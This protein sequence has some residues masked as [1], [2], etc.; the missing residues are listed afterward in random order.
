MKRV[1]VV[2]SALTL[3]VIAARCNNDGVISRKVVDKYE[4][5]FGYHLVVETCEAE[6][7]T[8]K[9]CHTDIYQVTEENYRLNEEGKEYHKP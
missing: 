1:I 4:N 9:P 6:G 3:M 2:L 8:L 7:T 5:Q